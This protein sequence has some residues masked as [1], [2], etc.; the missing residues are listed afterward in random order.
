MHYPATPSDQPTAAGGSLRHLQIA[1]PSTTCC[2]FGLPLDSDYGKSQTQNMNCYIDT[3]FIDNTRE[4]TSHR[5]ATAISY[6]CELEHRCDTMT[7]R[8]DD[9]SAWHPTSVCLSLLQSQVTNL[10]KEAYYGT[11]RFRIRFREPH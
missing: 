6:E 3:A 10:I 9:E 8:L 7:V 1:M 2:S 4:P 11:K 5:I